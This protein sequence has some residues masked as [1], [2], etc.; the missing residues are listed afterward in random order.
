MFMVAEKMLFIF[1]QDADKSTDNHYRRF[2][3]WHCPQRSLN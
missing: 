1:L 3:D 2:Y